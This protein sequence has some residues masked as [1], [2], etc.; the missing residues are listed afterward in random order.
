MIFRRITT[1]KWQNRAENNQ[2][3]RG[4]IRLSAFSCQSSLAVML[5][6]CR[7]RSTNYVP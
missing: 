5:S 2:Y 1:V 6:L 4:R 7:P 3:I